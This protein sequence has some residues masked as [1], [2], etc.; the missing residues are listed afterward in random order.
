MRF[1]K[2]GKK[3]FLAAPNKEAAEKCKK[4]KHL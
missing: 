4:G 3:A 1:S 2:H